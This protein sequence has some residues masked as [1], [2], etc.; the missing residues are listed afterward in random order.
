MKVG[1]AGG[2]LAKMVD[3]LRATGISVDVEHGKR[4]PLSL[5]CLL[6]WWTP[7][8]GDFRMVSFHQR[9]GARWGRSAPTGRVRMCVGIGAVS[10]AFASP[11]FMPWM[12]SAG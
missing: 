5:V 4:M 8:I 1:S 2:E 3:G 7:G 12:R 10:R 6:P 11:L 9:I